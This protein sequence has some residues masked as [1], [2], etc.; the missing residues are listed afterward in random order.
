MNETFQQWQNFLR[1]N[2]IATAEL[3]RPPAADADIGAAGQAMGFA[4]PRD[5][6]ALYRTADGQTD[7][8][9]AGAPPAG[10]RFA[11]L[12]GGYAF[13]SLERMVKEWRM[14]QSVRADFSDSAWEDMHE[15]I[16][17]RPG[18]PPVHREYWRPGWLPFATDGGGN[19]YAVDMD[20]PPG[21]MPGQII[22][23]GSDEDERRVL[24]TDLPS[25][26]RL[27]MEAGALAIDDGDEQVVYFLM[28]E[29]QN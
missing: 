6:A 16:T 17:L 3:L 19:S 5:L 25:L 18:D 29:K 2:G 9:K 28:R 4:L 12:F 14:W 21:G 15:P 27:T 11:P 7:P 13:N 20:P 23:I 1:G 26:L 24:A 22:V 10:Q 8:F